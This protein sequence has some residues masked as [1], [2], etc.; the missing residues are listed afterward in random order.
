MST[1]GKPGAPG[2]RGGRKSGTWFSFVVVAAAVVMAVSS[3]ASFPKSE[4]RADEG[5]FSF[6][7]P[8][9]RTK[10]VYAK[11][12]REKVGDLSGG[13]VMDAERTIALSD[14]R[15]E[16]VLLNLWGSWCAPC[17]GEVG[18]L[19]RL[20]ARYRDAGVRFLGVNVRDNRKSAQDFMNNLGVS[21][22]SVYDPDGKVTL[23][24]KGLPLSTVPVTLLL[25]R[26]HRVAAIFLGSVVG[27]NVTPEMRKVARS[28]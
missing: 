26:E 21:Y 18:E 1:R 25:D 9:G 8:D 6:V 24:L 11:D 13:S 27:K 28:G 19:E 14:Y 5:E 7:S 10:I 22:P 15:G 17:R 12:E 20:A 23:A 16:A 2:F 4:V 3:C